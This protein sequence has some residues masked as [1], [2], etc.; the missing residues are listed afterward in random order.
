MKWHKLFPPVKLNRGDV[1]RMATLIGEF[2][3]T[4]T[5]D[6]QRI[7]HVSSDVVPESLTVTSTDGTVERVEFDKEDA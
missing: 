3:T 7:T 1:V 6:G 5:V 4:A 2:A